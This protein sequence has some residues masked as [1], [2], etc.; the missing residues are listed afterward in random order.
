MQLELNDVM[1][2]I[3][4]C[5]GSFYARLMDSIEEEDQEAANELMKVINAY[6]ASICRTI[7]K[8]ETERVENMLDDM[9]GSE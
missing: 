8:A 5:N 4:L 7:E 2:I 3:G 9:E 1:H 6:T